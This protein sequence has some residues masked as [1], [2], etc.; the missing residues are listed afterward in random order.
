MKKKIIEKSE[1]IVKRIFTPDIYNE[2]TK[3]L[4]EAYDAPYIG[5]V[6]EIKGKI[7]KVILPENKKYSDIYVHDKVK[8][9]KYGCL[10]NYENYL[11]RFNDII[12]RYYSDL[13]V[14]ERNKKFKNKILSKE[15]YESQNLY[16]VDYDIEL[17]KG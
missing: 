16:L 3:D 14:E 17:C 5:F 11:E 15:E 10:Y 8:L 4:F 6:L 13:S 7:I 12:I 1:A 2:N 9:I